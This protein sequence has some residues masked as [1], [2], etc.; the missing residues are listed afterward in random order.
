MLEALRQDYV[1][2]AEAKG[3]ADRVVV[4]RHALRNA[5][6]PVVTSLGGILAGLISGALIIE[7]VFTWPGLGQ[8]TYQAAIAKDY[9]V[10][11]A[12][13]FI[14]SLLLVIS[15]ILRDVTYAFIDPRIGAPRRLAPLDHWL[16]RSGRRSRT[17]AR[18]ALPDDLARLRD[19]LGDRGTQL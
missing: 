8:F 14:S 10:V 12:G 15:Y 18:L 7:Q 4:V 11:Q 2:T 1:R 13:V 5:L 9:P 17:L 19:A 16:T 3:L 6:I